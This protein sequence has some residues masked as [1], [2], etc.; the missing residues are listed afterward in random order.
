[1]R[2]TATSFCL[3][4]LLGAALPSLAADPPPPDDLDALTLAD[5]APTAAVERPREWRVFVEGAVGTGRLRS[6][7]ANVDTSRAS[8]DLRYDATVAKSLRAVLSDRLDL[9]R[10]RGGNVQG[11]DINTLREAYLSWAPGAEQNIDLGRVNLRHGA[12]LGFNPTDWFKDGA[13]R[14]IV[15]PDP[16]MLREN[17]QGTVVLQGQQ[18]WNAGVLTA[19]FSPKL[20]DTPNPGS[21]FNLDFGATNP[22]DR[23]LVAGSYKL[24]DKFTPE[25]LAYGGAGM[26]TQFGLNLSGLVGDATVV[27]GEFTVGKGR[28]L[29]AQAMGVAEPERTQ[30]RAAVGLTYTTSFNL[31]VTVEADY[32]SAA[33]DRADWNAMWAVAPTSPG[34]LL[35]ASQ[36]QQD[37][38]VRRAG[39][40]HATWRDAGLRRLDLSGFVR[41]ETETHSRAQWLEA[42]YRW[43]R[44]EL[45]LQWQAFSGAPQTLFGPVPQRR[46]VELAL[47]FYL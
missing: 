33:P 30:R 15:S 43:E 6:P 2:P 39:F 16:A 10:A 44:T 23:W 32:N 47:R 17:R 25:V 27:F 20:G 36:L 19:A 41:F 18:L 1:M 46:S 37:L 34:Q 3:V 13:L 24:S 45:A 22:R 9:A 40:V 5:K 42:R 11:A 7:D 31:S 14:S 38:P 29:M 8:V 28:S 35:A 21:T 26:P 4:L 12:A